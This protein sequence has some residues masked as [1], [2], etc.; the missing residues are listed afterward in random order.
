MWDIFWMFSFESDKWNNDYDQ[1][2]IN[3]FFVLIQCFQNVLSVKLLRV[4]LKSSDKCSYYIVKKIKTMLLSAFN[5]YSL[6][7]WKPKLYH[8]H[9]W[10]LIS[11]NHR[12]IIIQYTFCNFFFLW[13]IPIISSCYCIDIPSYILPLTFIQRAI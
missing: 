8:R 11:S 13:F 9:L 2:F 7:E 10:K 12:A 3:I 6:A 4:E 1:Y 5:F